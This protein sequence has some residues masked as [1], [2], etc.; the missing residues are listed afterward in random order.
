MLI[1]LL[2]AFY[3]CLQ[4]RLSLTVYAYANSQLYLATARLLKQGNEP[5]TSWTASLSRVPNYTASFPSKLCFCAGHY[6]EYILFLEL[7]GMLG[8]AFDNN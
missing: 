3:G 8:G 1:T 7:I 2:Y 5:M 4:H 6:I